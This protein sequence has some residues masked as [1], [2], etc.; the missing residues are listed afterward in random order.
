[1]CV[2][3]TYQQHY[4][5]HHQQQQQQQQQQQHSQA[6]VS[7]LNSV[8]SQRG[9]HAL[10]YA[11]DAKWTIRQHLLDLLREFPSLQVKNG[12]YTHNDGRNAHLLR[13]EGTIP[14]FYQNVRYNVPVTIFLLEAYPRSAPLVYV[15]PTPDMIVK[16]RHSSV[17][18]SGKVSCDF[19]RGWMHPRANLV[20]LG[21]SLST[22]FSR[23]P[24]LFSKPPGWTPPPGVAQAFSVG[25]SPP[26]QQQQQQQQ[27]NGGQTFANP[28]QPHGNGGAASASASAASSAYSGSAA[29]GSQQQQRP[30]TPRSTFRTDAIARI[31]HRIG[32]ALSSQQQHEQRTLESLF[33]EQNALEER[34]KTLEKG[35][36]ELQAE[37]EALEN[38]VGQLSEASA[39]MKGWLKDHPEA[40]AMARSAAENG[41][42]SAASVVQ[43][44]FDE[45]VT[46]RD[47]RGAQLLAA[48][49]EDLA[50]EDALYALEDAFR[51]GAVEAGDYLKHTRM[52]C[53]SQFF[54]R[55][56]QNKLL[57][58]LASAGATSAPS[59]SRHPSHV[60]TLEGVNPMAARS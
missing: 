15:C 3:A 28:M 50:I 1:V 16:P 51:H 23:D 21:R 6:V 39:R 4:Q 47:P 26:G 29:A 5:K 9:Q 36:R 55:A 46:A 14:M 44:P 27:H 22:L 42:A 35:C 18:P 45:A 2:G 13:T 12:T 30:Q 38:S 59:A 53:R 56:K 52:L 49:A 43:P 20:D 41:D 17:D 40:V 37:R 8:L 33:E 48:R 57:S 58:T 34:G 31:T 10:P 11:E 24:P 54:E 7:Y 60:A 19:L 25:G 32:V